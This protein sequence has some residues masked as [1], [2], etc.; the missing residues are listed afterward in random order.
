MTFPYPSRTCRTWHPLP[1]VRPTTPDRPPVQQPGLELV[2]LR[3]GF[4]LVLTA[5]ATADGLKAALRRRRA[6]T[7]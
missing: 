1:D 5:K 3:K 6:E 4:A 7:G 2:V